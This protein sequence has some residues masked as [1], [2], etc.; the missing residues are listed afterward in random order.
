MCVEN[1]RIV[2]VFLRQLIWGVTCICLLEKINIFPSISFEITINVCWKPQHSDCFSET[3]DLRGHMLRFNQKM[4]VFPSI[5]WEITI[6]VCWNP[7]HRDHFSEMTNLRGHMP[8]LYLKNECFPIYLLRKCQKCVLEP[9]EQG[10]FFWD[11]QFEGSH[12]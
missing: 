4:N 8:M 6:N 10:L 7:Q 1:I 11:N 3:I 2:I 12:A 9:S 5:S